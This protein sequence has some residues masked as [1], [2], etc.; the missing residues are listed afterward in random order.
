MTQFA[1]IA[2]GE[3]LALDKV[4]LLEV[5]IFRKEI[6]ER[7]S[8]GSRIV[9][10]FGVWPYE[11][12]N[13]LSPVRLYGILADDARHTLLPLTTDVIKEYLSRTLYTL[14]WEIALNY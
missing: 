2:N 8:S 6:I 4:P 5:A 12:Q 10:L 7:V 9:A 3:P 1:T 13:A 11:S 14:S